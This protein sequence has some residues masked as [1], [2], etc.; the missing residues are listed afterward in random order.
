MRTCRGGLIAAL[1]LGFV[2]VGVGT[3]PMP[4]ST[5]LGTS[6]L[7]LCV[8]EPIVSAC[9]PLRRLGKARDKPPPS[10]GGG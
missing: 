8:N 2:V 4:M 6:E 9:L 3:L 1:N 5:R 10:G 7:G